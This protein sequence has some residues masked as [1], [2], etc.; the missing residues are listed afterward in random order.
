ML[1]PTSNV[2]AVIYDKAGKLYKEGYGYYCKDHTEWFNGFKP[3]NNEQYETEII[4]L[5]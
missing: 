5:D 1:R 4:A 3:I 2:Y